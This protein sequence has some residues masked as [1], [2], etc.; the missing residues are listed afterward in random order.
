LKREALTHPK[1]KLL[2]RDLNCSINEVRGLMWALWG[3]AGFSFPRG[4]VGRLTNE[5][6][7]L[8]VDY[9]GEHDFLIERLISRRLLDEVDDEDGRLFVH[10]WHEHADDSVQ[11]KLARA[12]QTFA[13]GV[14]SKRTKTDDDK[15]QPKKPVTPQKRQSQTKSDKKRQSATVANKDQQ[16]PTGQTE[17]NRT[18]P[19]GVSPSSPPGDEKP[20]LVLLESP[21]PWLEF[22]EVYPKR[23]G[24]L[25]KAKA[26]TIFR[27]LAKSVDPLQIIDGAR[28]YG[29]YCEAVGRVKTEFVKQMPTF[30]N[31]RGWEEEFEAPETP[32]RGG[33]SRN[34]IDWSKGR[35]S[36]ISGAIEAVSRG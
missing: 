13:N 12:G 34:G 11:Y 24:D 27:R 31:N 18:E 22:V 26:E 29:E 20:D 1:L 2:A 5:E 14:P 6:I 9:E 19:Y 28:R 15:D 25:G 30:L 10:D 17:L 35:E 16:S 3:L 21:D 7:A 33:K 23:A 4:D 36:A 8:A 32:P